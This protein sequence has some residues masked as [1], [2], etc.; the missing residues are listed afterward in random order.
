MTGNLVNCAN[1]E[2]E[3]SQSSHSENESSNIAFVH[4]HVK[5]LVDGEQKEPERSLDEPVHLI[6]SEIAS[7]LSTDD[8]CHGGHQHQEGKPGVLGTPGR[9]EEHTVYH[10][11]VFDHGNKASQSSPF[12]FELSS[13]DDGVK[14]DRKSCE[15]YRTSKSIHV[16]NE[17][18]V[19]V[20]CSIRTVD[21]VVH[22]GVVFSQQVSHGRTSQGPSESSASSD[23][24]TDQ[25]NFSY[26]DYSHNRVLAHTAMP[27]FPLASEE[28]KRAQADYW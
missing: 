15:S 11:P 1:C 20:W 6:T 13:S 21:H 16:R 12:R 5:V 22:K 18:R 7:D 9:L 17:E 8:Q 25:L 3:V 24:A 14:L 4:G 19:F 2:L 10:A 23:E 28:H 26:S 27:F